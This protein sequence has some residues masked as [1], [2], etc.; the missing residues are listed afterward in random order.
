MAETA[1]KVVS[2]AG[3][4]AAAAQSAHVSATGGFTARELVFIL[5]LSHFPVCSL[6]NQI[7]MFSDGNVLLL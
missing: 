5:L 4:S 7:A 1:H 6:V 3:G 2:T